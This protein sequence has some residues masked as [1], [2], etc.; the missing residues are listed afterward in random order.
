VSLLE[1]TWNGVED[2]FNAFIRDAREKAGHLRIGMSQWR[3]MA[4]GFWVY[5]TGG[6]MEVLP[7][8]TVV[9]QDDATITI[10]RG[11]EHGL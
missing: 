11:D 2:P 1:Y 10:T 8:D 6:L 4:W 9:L 7:G 5:T 3:G